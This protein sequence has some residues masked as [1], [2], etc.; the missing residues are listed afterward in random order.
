[1]SATVFNDVGTGCGLDKKQGA[2]GDGNKPAPEVVDP[3]RCAKCRKLESNMFAFDLNAEGWRACCCTS[4]FN[5]QRHF[6]VV[7]RP[8]QH[9]HAEL[10]VQQR[11]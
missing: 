3:C 11:R 9:V 8:R 7:L 4:L 5:V 2:S 10:H 6:S 1:M